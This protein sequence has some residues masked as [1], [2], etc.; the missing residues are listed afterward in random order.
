MALGQA[1]TLAESHKQHGHERSGQQGEQLNHDLPHP[2]IAHVGHPSV[3]GQG[4]QQWQEDQR[5]QYVREI[6]RSPRMHQLRRDARIEP[7][8]PRPGQ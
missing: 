7:P 3:V 8:A 5:C 6:H 2:E 1:V 4:S